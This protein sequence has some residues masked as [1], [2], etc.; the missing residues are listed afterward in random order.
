MGQGGSAP[1]K[2]PG[3]DATAL[4]PFLPLQ[5]WI[6]ILE[7]NDEARALFDR[8]YSRRRYA[9]GRSPRLFVGPGEK[10]VLTT[11]CRRALFVWRRERY[12][13]N[14][15][16]G[17]N[18]AVFRNEGAALSSELIRAADEIADARWPG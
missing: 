5:A 7:G 6:T 8:H 14:D 4:A 1:D 12:S 13:A 9:D 3:G 10:L 15:Q 17:V 16:T 18:C 2:P 11:P